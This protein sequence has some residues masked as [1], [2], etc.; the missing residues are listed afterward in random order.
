M[1]VVEMN[2]LA[3]GISKK[4]FVESGGNAVAQDVRD[5]SDTGSKVTIVAGRGD[6]GGP[7]LVAARFLRTHDVR[8]LLLGRPETITTSTT[9]E[10]WEALSMAEEDI[11]AVND[12]T[13]LD[14][15][16]P[17]IIVDGIFGIEFTGKPTEP[18]RTAIEKINATAAT[19]ISVEIPSGMNANSGEVA[20]TAVSA[21]RTITFHDLKPGLETLS[22]VTVAEIGIPQAAE[23]I[24][25]PG[26]LTPIRTRL[27]GNKQ[28]GD[29]GRVFV[30]G[31]GP[32]TG[33]PA[34]S[35]QA[36]LRAG[37]DLV[38]VAV[39]DAIADTIRGYSE[40]LIIQPFS[41]TKL[42]LD[43]VDSLVETATKYNDIVVVGPGLGEADETQ[44][45][46]RTFLTKFDGKV[47]VDADALSIVPDSR[48]DASLIL[49]P[50]Q[51]EVHELGGPV[52]RNLRDQ[53]E[54]LEALAAELD[55][56][57]LVKGEETVITD[58]DRTQIVREGPPGM[59]TGGTGDVLSG[60]VAAF[61]G[62]ASPFDAACAAAYVKGAAGDKLAEQFGR[63]FTASDL[64]EAIPSVLFDRSEHE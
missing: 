25:G 55:H 49:T 23:S 5:I 57:L 54:E 20:D 12:S 44:A 47:V 7:A 46:V 31:G 34:L 43:P 35:A 11:H 19:T 6:N 64:L 45:A 63:G 56:T 58:G 17:D 42:T 13:E 30:I 38:F 24:V 3:L 50:N 53:V 14:V 51:Q 16:N 10:N 33:A 39:P 28:E 37:A 18:E 36:A 48:T 60:V 61:F 2:A 40:N 4:Q 26:D 15:D 9:R 1:A 27:R 62:V 21:D 52:V 41:G 29:S 59:T 22:E 32:Y 8:V